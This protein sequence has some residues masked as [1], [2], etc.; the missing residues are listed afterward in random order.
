[1]PRAETLNPPAY[2]NK[3]LLEHVSS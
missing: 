1:M 3:V 2:L